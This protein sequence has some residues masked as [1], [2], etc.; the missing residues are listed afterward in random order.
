MA[1]YFIDPESTLGT[2]IKAFLLLFIAFFLMETGRPLIAQP[3][4]RIIIQFQQ[5]LTQESSDEFDRY[6]ENLLKNNYKVADHSSNNRW[7]LIIPS[8]LSDNV[9]ND[10]IKNIKNNTKVKYVESDQLLRKQ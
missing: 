10:V 7:I 9:I 6:L 1:A 8:T 5:T 3:E 4:L 2:C